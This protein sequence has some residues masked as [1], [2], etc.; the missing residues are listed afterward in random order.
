MTHKLSKYNNSPQEKWDLLKE[1]I[2]RLLKTFT[3]I[4]VNRGMIR[5]S[6]SKVKEMIPSDGT[7]IIQLV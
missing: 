1:M 6:S 7:P 4:D 2:K 5:S 3:E